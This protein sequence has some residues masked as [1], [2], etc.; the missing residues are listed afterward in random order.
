MYF[1]ATAIAT[2]LSLAAAGPIATRE[3]SCATNAVT[4]LNSLTDEVNGLKTTAQGITLAGMFIKIPTLITG[5]TKTISTAT[6][7]AT[8]LRCDEELSE[9]DQ[10]KV[11]A[12]AEAFVKADQGLV[13]VLI[14]KQGIINYGP[15]AAPLQAVTRQFESATDSLVFGVLDAA[16]TCAG[17]V[18]ELVKTLDKDTQHLQELLEPSPQV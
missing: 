14:G 17:S 6:L 18:E 8:N 4:T 11:C 16:P 10:K 1:K 3:A 5:T 12:A 2:L 13:Y 9:E 15:F 7:A